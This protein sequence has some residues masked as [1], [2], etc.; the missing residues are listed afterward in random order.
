VRRQV[1]GPDTLGDADRVQFAQPGGQI[2]QRPAVADQQA[3]PDL[4]EG[5]L[6][7]GDH[8]R[9][10]R[11]DD[12]LG[13]VEA[14]SQHGH[15]IRHVP[16]LLELHVQP[17]PAAAG[18]QHLGEQRRPDAGHG[19]DVVAGQAAHRR[20]ADGRVVEGDQLAVAGPADIELDHVGTDIDRVR[21][22][23]D[24]VLGGPGR[25]APVRGNHGT[26]HDRQ[27]ALLR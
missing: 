17:D 12:H 19:L 20:A 27:Y 10:E 13:R 15:H 9:K 18:P 6:R 8:G 3:G 24:R 14:R 23:R 7:L 4:R 2:G 22:G 16:V 26:D 1:V 25:D 11:R 5:V 21:E